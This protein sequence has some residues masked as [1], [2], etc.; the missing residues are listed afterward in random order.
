M[1]MKLRVLLGIAERDLVD[2][3]SPDNPAL[4]QNDEIHV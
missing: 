3:S 1:V 2:Y 4:Q